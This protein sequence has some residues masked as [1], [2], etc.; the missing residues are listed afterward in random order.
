MI[1]CSHTQ[2]NWF[3]ALT[4]SSPNTL[5]SIYPYKFENKSKEYIVS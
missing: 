4:I 5:W 1:M 3:T 2:F